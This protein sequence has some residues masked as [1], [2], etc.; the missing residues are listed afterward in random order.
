MPAPVAAPAEPAAVAATTHEI[1]P[2]SS[3]PSEVASGT[4]FRIKRWTQLTGSMAGQTYR[5]L[6]AAMISSDRTVEELMERSDLER[7]DILRLLQV[8]R[9]KGV[10]TEIAPMTAADPI[11]VSTQTQAAPA[12]A[13]SAPAAAATQPP[14]WPAVCSAR[15]AAGLA[16]TA[17]P[18][19][20]DRSPPCNTRSNA[21]C[22]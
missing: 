7:A 19:T 1:E 16:R 22:C 15:S 6:L 9:G 5:Q 20:P 2:A 10:L 17:T 4:R 13:F 21:L 18:P 3:A 11:V 8:L 14:A 12:A